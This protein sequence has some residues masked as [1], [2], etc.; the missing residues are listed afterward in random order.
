[1][2]RP[3]KIRFWKK[4]NASSLGIWSLLLIIRPLVDFFSN[5]EIDWILLIIEGVFF[6]VCFSMYFAPNFFN[7]ILILESDK[8]IVKD[9]VFSKK[10]SIDVN[11]IKSIDLYKLNH[12]EIWIIFKL[13]GDEEIT[14]HTRD[15]TKEMYT[16][17]INANPKWS[18]SRTS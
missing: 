8:L 3:I 6:T 7:Y 16:Q 14:W 17:L 4:E 5:R 13:F 11:Q 18:N 10:I 15:R 12:E 1:M 2:E 9:G